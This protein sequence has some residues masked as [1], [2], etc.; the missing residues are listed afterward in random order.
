[1]A[2]KPAGTIVVYHPAAVE[3][4]QGIKDKQARK[5]V[6]TIVAILAKAG[7]SITEP[8]AKK[9]QGE[10]KL[11]ELRPGGGKTLLRPL[12]AQI[13]AYLVILAI[14]PEAQ[15]DPS[16]FAAAVKRAKRRAKDNFGVEV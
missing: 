3:D 10:A 14:G 6:L 1:M 5:K 12:Y 15:A 9:V 16:G 11:Y 2:K 13:D 7:T 4:F 8:H